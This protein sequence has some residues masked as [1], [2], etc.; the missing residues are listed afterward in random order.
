[1]SNA[2]QDAGDALSEARN[3]VELILMTCPKEPAE[4]QKAIAAGAYIAIGRL[5][6]GRSFLGMTLAV[7]MAG[8]Q[9]SL[10]KLRRLSMD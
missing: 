6:R 1:M 4:D 2:I 8:R 5:E 9:V 3:Q 10:P 7:R